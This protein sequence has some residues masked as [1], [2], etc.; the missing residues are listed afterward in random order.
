[1]KLGDASTAGHLRSWR[2]RDQSQRGDVRN[3]HDCYVHNVAPRQKARTLSPRAIGPRQRPHPTYWVF[4][5]IAPASPSRLEL[6]EPPA[7]YLP[8]AGL[9][10]AG[11]R[12]ASPEPRSLLLGNGLQPQHLPYT[13]PQPAPP[14]PPPTRG[15]PADMDGCRA[16][17]RSAAQQHKKEHV[18]ISR[19]YQEIGIAPRELLYLRGK[20]GL[21]TALAS[22]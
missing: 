10:E 17:L 22:R 8:V 19:L 20:T 18:Q 21:A 15:E 1:M 13:S 16:H 11:A 5:G 3:C 7:P 4:V 2:R 14:R 6:D 9:H 12:V